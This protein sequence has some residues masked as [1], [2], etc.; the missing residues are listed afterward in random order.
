MG[1]R[2]RPAGS[3]RGVGQDR[4]ARQ[5]ASVRTDWL[6][7]RRR[8]GPTGQEFEEGVDSRLDRAGGKRP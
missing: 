7:K 1:R 8:S 3:T 6:D 2:S 4:S 5:E